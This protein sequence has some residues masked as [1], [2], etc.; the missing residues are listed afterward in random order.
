VLRPVG[1]PIAVSGR[2]KVKAADL[3]KKLGDAAWFV[4]LTLWAHRAPDGNTT[5][6][7]EGLA[8]AKG[9]A[10]VAL[11][12]VRKATARLKGASVLESIG[13]RLRNVPAGKGRAKRWV[14]VRRV[15]GA[16]V[17][18]SL[19]AAGLLF[20]P[21]DTAR[22]MASAT[23]WGG[24][25]AGSGRQ[26]KNQE[27]PIDRQQNVGDPMNQ[28]GPVFSNTPSFPDREGNQE[29]PTVFQE[30]P[31]SGFSRGAADLG[32][33]IL[34]SS[35][36]QNPLASL[37]DAA[38]AT[39]RA[40]AVCVR[41]FSGGGGPTPNPDSGNQPAGLSPTSILPSAP[42]PI[43]PSAPNGTA[44]EQKGT[45]L[46]A[47]DLGTAN[48]PSANPK[49]VKGLLLCEGGRIRPRPPVLP[50]SPLPGAPPLPWSMVGL[51]STPNPP[52]LDDD[53]SDVERAHKLA[54]AFRGAVRARFNLVAWALRAGLP[55]QRSK[56]FKTLVDGAAELLRCEIAPAA[57]AAWSCDV[58]KQ[59][60]SNKKPPPVPWVFSAKRITERR[61]WFAAEEESYMGGRIIMGPVK[62]ALL[63]Q[64]MA[65]RFAIDEAAAW[66]NPA[67]IVAQFFP[68]DAYDQAVKAARAEVAKQQADLR[69][70]A[71][72]GAF[73]W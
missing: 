58:W 4:L 2:A 56:F 23:T 18:G 29:G 59:Y 6:T 9:F 69:R 45:V 30:G 46:A 73:L 26:K 25:R 12:V 13:W 55:I 34:A 40:S 66:A 54:D 49:G 39:S 14:F 31:V 64:Y 65:M 10:P 15:L 17:E 19:G 62:R 60:N 43:L 70:D 36:V 16:E 51:A 37:G 41:S 5:I 22:W 28:E 21:A 71:D 50:T 72:S 27:G 47:S 44:V 35:T 20:V 57:W 48:P 33:K 42:T 38:L 68:G 32:S 67:R 52:L 53:M 61:G 8:R 24:A 1:V 7:N 63:E 11:R 3:R